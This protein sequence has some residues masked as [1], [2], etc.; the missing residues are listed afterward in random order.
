MSP[1]VVFV[2]G[3][4]QTTPNPQCWQVQYT[5]I[6]SDDIETVAPTLTP[7]F[8]LGPAGSLTLNRVEVIAGHGSIEGSYSGTNTFNLF[9]QP[10][11]RSFH[12]RPT[13]HTR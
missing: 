5:Q 7:A 11:R 8:S 6:Y 2:R 3:D 13:T 10:F 12:S 4:A 1:H 9:L